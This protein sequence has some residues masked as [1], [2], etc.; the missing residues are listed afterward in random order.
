MWDA[1]RYLRISQEYSRPFFDLLN[2]IKRDDFRTIV[3][4]GCG[5]GNLTQVLTERWPNATVVGV[6]SSPEMLELAKPGPRLRFELG[7]IRS[8]R[9]D[10]PLDLIISNAA[11]QWVPDHARLLP[12]L[13]EMLAPNGVL[14]VQMPDHFAMPVSRAIAEAVQAGPWRSALRGV[15][16][17]PDTVKPIE[18]YATFLR[19]LGL[20][21]NAWASSYCRFLRGE[22]LVLDW[23]SATALRPMLSVLDTETAK[24][25]LAVV[26]ERF[27]AH[28]PQTGDVTPVV[29]KRLLFAAERPRGA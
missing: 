19:D 29:S 12:Q 11:L 10:T 7:D 3:D 27:L 4:L 15:G 20:E 13:I 5:P 26:G 17:H 21:V 2:Q 14:A 16:Q 23:M 22:N 9:P 1:R 25:F 28:Y 8:W 18:W 6:D 24:R